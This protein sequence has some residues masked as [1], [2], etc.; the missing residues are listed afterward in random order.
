MVKEESIHLT[1]WPKYDEK[2]I[3]KELEEE[4]ERRKEEII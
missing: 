1:S 3:D 4:I 2:S